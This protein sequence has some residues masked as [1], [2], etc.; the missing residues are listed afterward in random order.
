MKARDLQNCRLCGRGIAHA[1]HISFWTVSLQRMGL[2]K[3]GINRVAGMEQFF[4]GE[5]AIARVFCDDDIAQPLGDPGKVFVCETCALEKPITHLWELLP[6]A[7]EDGQ[8][9]E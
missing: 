9:D 8:E 4:G 6:Q 3:K 5:V 2:D 1:G 7:K